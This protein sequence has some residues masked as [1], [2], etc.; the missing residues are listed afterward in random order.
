MLHERD[1]QPDPPSARA[2]RRFVSEALAGSSHLDDVILTAS[3]LASNVIRHAHTPY[4]VRVEHD[5][6]L[7]RLEISDGSSI[8]PAIEDLAASQRGLRVV[9]ATSDNWGI[10]GTDNGKTIWAEF[11]TRQ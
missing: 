2:V 8:V 11:E 6:D 7:I 3:E 1:F 10:E 5:E 4:T 9:T